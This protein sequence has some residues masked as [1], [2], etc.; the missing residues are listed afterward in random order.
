[1]LNIIVL[2]QTFPIKNELEIRLHHNYSI[3]FDT[4]VLRTETY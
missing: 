3:L 4:T 1:M 2:E